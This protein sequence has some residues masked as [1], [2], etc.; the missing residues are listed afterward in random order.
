MKNSLR[1]VLMAGAVVVAGAGVAFSQIS[2]TSQIETPAPTDMAGQAE[3]PQG[4]F[5]DRF[6]AEFDLN[7][8]RKVTKDEF[9]KVVA[10]H[11]MQASGGK[12]AMTVEQFTNAHIAAFK[13][14]VGDM[15]H[16]IDWNGDGRLS[17]EEFAAPIHARFET[18]DRDGTG[19]A[20]C[21]GRSDASAPQADTAQNH[22]FQRRHYSGSTRGRGNLCG[23]YDVD[24]SGRLSRAQL[25]KAV[26]VQFAG[27]AKGNSMSFAQFY[28]LELARYRDLNARI[29]DRIDRDRNGA[30][31]ESEYAAS[32]MRFFTRLDKNNDGTIAQDEIS[33][34]RR[35]NWNA[36]RQKKSG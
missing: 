27:A 26:Q 12:P 21:F 8:D 25:D 33:F 14:R 11:F 10:Q 32:E 15:F 36:S 4:R 23:Q 5:A 28:G 20:R 34:H 2:Q 17:L 13:Q 16:R 3:R 9:N 22:P 35:S 29:F 1:Y 31:S 6:M 7:H 24:H 18:M 30:I 19:T